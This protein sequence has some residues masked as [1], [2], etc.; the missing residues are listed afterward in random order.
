MLGIY[1]EFTG[2]QQ[3]NT[4]IPLEKFYEH[5]RMTEAQKARFIED[6]L[7]AHI[8]FKKGDK[9]V[10]EL[11]IKNIYPRDR[12]IYGWVRAVFQ[13]MPY[14]ILLVLNCCNKYY[15]FL[16]ADVKNRQNERIVNTDRVVTAVYNDSGWINVDNPDHLLGGDS[17]PIDSRYFPCVI[18]GEENQYVYF[19]DDNGNEI[20]G[21]QINLDFIQEDELDKF[22]E[23]VQIRYNDYD[24]ANDLLHLDDEYLETATDYFWKEAIANYP[25]ANP[26]FLKMFR[27]IDNTYYCGFVNGELIK[28][29]DIRSLDN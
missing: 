24:V 11:Q 7:L 8:L 13:T 21:P 3:V 28:W 23:Y 18:P 20:L 22:M 29:S 14:D 25:G 6:V 27:E 15:L 9:H 2:W 1:E 4:R 5:G 19:I 10:V 26:E 17:S 12:L 16:S